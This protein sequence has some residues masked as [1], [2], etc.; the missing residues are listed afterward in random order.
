MTLNKIT[1]EVDL[2]GEDVGRYA[3]NGD[4]SASADT[5]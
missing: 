1:I 4:I 2:G 5:S 3:G